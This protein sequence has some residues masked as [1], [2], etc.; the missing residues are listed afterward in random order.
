MTITV[1]WCSRTD[2]DGAVHARTLVAAT[3]SFAVLLACAA[4]ATAQQTDDARRPATAVEIQAGYAGFVDDAT[5]DH[6]LIGAS[7]RFYLTPRLGVGPEL[8]YMRGP[9]NDRDI[10][11]TGNLTFDFRGPRSGRPP[12]V[13]PYLVAGGGWFQHRDRFGTFTFSSGEGTFTAGGGARVWASDRVYA[14]A[15]YRFG[16]ELHYRVTGHVGVALGAR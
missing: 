7:A 15:E 11:V 5:I 13:V 1:P 4:D 10:F 16:W 2:R 12:R 6:G 9:R 14:G 3:V 8:V